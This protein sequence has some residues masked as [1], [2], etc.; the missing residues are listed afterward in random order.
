MP[1]SFSC[2]GCGHHYTVAESQAGKRGKCKQC[3]SVLIVPAATPESSPPDL[4]GL[5][6]TGAFPGRD[7]AEKPAAALPRHGDGPLA[8]RPHGRAD[9]GAVPGWSLWLV[10]LGGVGLGVLVA[11]LA[12]R[13]RRAEPPPVVAE[14]LAVS[15][16]P[17]PPPPPG[18]ERDG[19]FGFPQAQAQVVYDQKDTLRVSVWNNA[20]FLYVQ[21]IVWGD[22]EDVQ[23]EE[24]DGRP[25]GDSSVLSLD[26]DA[27]QAPTPRVD[28][29]YALNPFA[30]LPGLRYYVVLSKTGTSG[31]KDDSG[32][33]GAI[34]HI[35]AGD[36]RRVRV[37]SFAVPLSEI[38]KRPGEKIRLAYW[39][40]SRQPSRLLN[41]VGFSSDKPYYAYNLPQAK[42]HEVTLSTRSAPFDLAQVPEGRGETPLAI[43]RSAPKTSPSRQPRPVEPVT[44]SGKT[45]LERAILAQFHFDGDASDSSGRDHWFSLKNTVFKD[46]ALYLNGEYEYG[47]GTDGYRAQCEFPELNYDGFTVALR[48]K[49]ESFAGTRNTFLVGGTS[50]R[51]FSLS[52]SPQGSLQ[53]GLN[54]QDLMRAVADTRIDEDRWYVVMCGVDL[55]EGQIVAYLDRKK[56]AEITLPR[57]FKLRAATSDRGGSDKLW[58]FTN[59]SNG[60][61]FH[62]LID[63]FMV[64]DRMLTSDEF[65]EAAGRLRSGSSGGAPAGPLVARSAATTELPAA[66]N[67]LLNDLRQAGNGRLANELVREID[68]A[69]DQVE[70]TGKSNPQ[71]RGHVIVG[72]VVTEEWDDPSRVTAQMRIHAEGYFV[73]PVASSGRPV[74]FRRQGYLPAE[75][76]PTGVPGTVESVGEI[77]LQPLPE[78]MGAAVRG[79]VDLAGESQTGTSASASLWIVPGPINTPSNSIA[80]MMPD[81]ASATVSGTGEFSASGLSPTQYSLT[82]AAPGYVSQWRSAALKPG[83]TLDLGTITLE[84]ARQIAVSYRVASSPPFTQ[85]RA[86]RQT[87]QGGGSFRANP[88]DFRIDLQFVQNQGE[89]RLQSPYPTASIADLG[90]GTL[91][92]FLDVDPAT[93]RLSQIRDVVPQPGHVY[94]LHQESF[95]RWV[96]LQLEFDQATPR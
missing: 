59:Y 70:R 54:N 36:G 38:Q 25:R 33:R 93:V 10:G 13:P 82:I 86:E 53:I 39:A 28:R 14:R 57:D 43:A 48:F 6:E 75:I 45:A 17:A 91:D 72:R 20:E 7:A 3:G 90:P 80:G 18:L 32:G 30:D 9:R 22:D 21:A 26:V 4:Y 81:T 37:D 74:G 67:S 71:R 29:N 15:T 85:A 42:Y 65:A 89:I 35:D 50:Y 95:K 12:L 41:S 27:D 66:V 49:S 5:N 87:V 34:R 64:F 56:V 23:A 52:R 8:R 19:A 2:T 84:R 69:R 94:L 88:Q 24:S 92:D 44:A 31:L 55:K 60:S 63:E 68:Q 61:V 78:A 76:M 77:R 73:G 58:L 16:V 1:I 40:S 47:S 11:M 79:K 83:Q 96:L 51:W 46:N 62:G